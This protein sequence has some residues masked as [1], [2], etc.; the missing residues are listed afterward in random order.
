MIRPL[1]LAV[2]VLAA[3]PALASHYRA[4]PETQPAKA[5]FVARHNVWNC[6]A[7]SCVSDR[8]AARPAIVCATLVREVG[9]LR[10]FS[11]E[12]RPFE[13]A[14]L[15]ACNRRALGRIA[16]R[17]PTSRIGRRT[18]PWPDPPSRHFGATALPAASHRR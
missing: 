4:E 18:I 17:P 6:A 10:S 15:E 5:R 3:T 9:A 8:S 7:G 13:A 2:A 14:A 12:N 1:A 11:V 16:I